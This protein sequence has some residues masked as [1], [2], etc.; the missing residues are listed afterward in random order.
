MCR[1]LLVCEHNSALCVDNVSSFLSTL[2]VNCD[3]G[4]ATS[5]QW[6]HQENGEGFA[7]VP[8]LI[9]NQLL[10]RALDGCTTL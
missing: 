6:H 4:W 7:D 5:S 9:P 2:D 1:L 10:R 8:M 3:R